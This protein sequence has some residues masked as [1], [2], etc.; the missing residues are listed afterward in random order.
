MKI[1]V[2]SDTHGH[3]ANTQAAVEKLEQLNVEQIL[4]CGDVGGSEVVAQFEQWP[5]HFVSG[6][7]DYPDQ[8]GQVVNSHQQHW[9]GMF[10]DLSLGGKR[11]ALLHSHEEHRFHEAKHSGD[12]DLV[13]YGHTHVKEHHTVGNTI[14]LNP[15]AMYRAPI[16]T[17]AIVDLETMEIEHIEL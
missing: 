10:G 15:G 14:V 11:I 16:F 4:H 5:T 13:C 1:G 8:L 6:N 17:F 12:Y 7:C 3:A 9:E 2:I